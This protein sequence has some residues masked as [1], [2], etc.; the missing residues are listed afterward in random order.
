MDTIEQTELIEASGIDTAK[1]LI[2]GLLGGGKFNTV[3]PAINEGKYKSAADVILAHVRAEGANREVIEGIERAGH[4][5]MQAGQDSENL[6]WFGKE[7]VTAAFSL[8]NQYG[9]Y[10][11]EP[12]YS[13]VENS[14]S[15][16]I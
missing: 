3:L 5:L 4:A 15:E 16:E 1:M 9:F 12:D 10:K 8:R 7:L 2:D 14:E 6:G 11:E 13:E